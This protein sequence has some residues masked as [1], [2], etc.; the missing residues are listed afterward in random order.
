[1][2]ITLI[3]I[4]FGAAVGL[5]L[6][7]EVSGTLLLIFAGGLLAVVLDAAV[8]A[9][10]RVLPVGRI[11]RLG[12]V[13]IAAA[14]LIGA[15]LAFGGISLL[16]QLRSLIDG[17]SDQWAALLGWL[18]GQGVD[19]SNLPEPQEAM[20][21]LRDNL[22]DAG[23]I[24]SHVQTMF[25]SVSGALTNAVVIVFLGLFFAADPAGYRDGFLKLIPVDRRVRVGEVLVEAG[26][27]L[28]GW[29][30][31]QLAMMALV[32]VSVAI[33]L[34]AFGIAN[35]MLLGLLAGLLNFVP[36]LGPILAAIPVLLAVAPEGLTTLLL[37]GGLFVVIQSIEGYLIGP[38]IQQRAVHLPPAWSLAAL[39]VAGAL[40][41][42]IG[43]ALATP[44]LAV[45]R[46]LVLRLY[47]EDG[48]E[49]RHGLI[50]T[51]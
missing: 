46:I 26:L 31:G 43:I 32:G 16:D 48:L 24:F 13:T 23:M 50:K 35:A 19:L 34:T 14:A 51:V 5:Y 6:A 44:L 20:A 11:W 37:V 41:G 25:G 7:W 29:L 1:M 45:I 12:I 9:L 22:P 40:F 8:A 18:D 4:A 42:G 28:R 36:F 38:L 21:T 39:L 27:S 3:F 47:V 17:A 49:R 15:G 33:L 10:G 30:L 2:P